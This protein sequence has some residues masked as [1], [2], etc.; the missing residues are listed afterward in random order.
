MNQWLGSVW[1]SNGASEALDTG[2]SE[3][4]GRA[5]GPS[6][7]QGEILSAQRRHR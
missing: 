2:I 5:T 3:S 7:D 4:G 6:R 1:P